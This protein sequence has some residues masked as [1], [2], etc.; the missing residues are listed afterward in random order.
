[1][2]VCGALGLGSSGCLKKMILDGQI[3]STR[4]AS[5]AVTTIGDWEVAQ[6]ITYAG[7]AQFEGMHYLAPENLD[8]LFML[9]KSWSG[10]A[11]G[12]IED[13]LER[14]E[15]AHG[16]MSGEYAYHKARAVAAYS[17]AIYYGTQALD[18]MNP[19]Y[20]Q[21][22]RNA[23]TMRAWLQGFD[24]AEEHVPQLFWVGQAWLG[25]TGLMRDD[26][27][28]V[29]E[30]FVGY[31]IIKRAVELDETYL[32]GSG[33]VMLG[34]YHARSRMAELDESKKHFE[35]ALQINGG[36]ALLTKFQYAVRY[37]C[38]KMDKESYV[39]LLNEVLDAGDVLPHA[40]LNNAI[41]KRRAKRALSEERMEMCGFE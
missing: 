24:D 6:R 5:A 27:A 29:S 19:G 22:K 12:F 20:D 30:L 15:D 7:V 16:D 23:K 38:A 18:M 28:T 35:R 4:K 3:A 36:K 21:A 25:R 14:A 1:M 31:E 17:R 13:E 39:R 37:Y 32:D 41:A 2:L 10:M 26:P 33:H 11:F 40:R 34:A 9:T 8:A